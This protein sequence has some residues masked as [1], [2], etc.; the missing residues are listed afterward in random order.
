MRY[1]VDRLAH[2]MTMKVEKKTY[3]KN[4]TTEFDFFQVMCGLSYQ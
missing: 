1:F 2:H 4:I 3:M